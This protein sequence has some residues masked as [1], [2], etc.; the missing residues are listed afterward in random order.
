MKV[1]GA[2]FTSH[3]ILQ[4]MSDISTSKA[5]QSVLNQIKDC[6]IKLRNSRPESREGTYMV[7]PSEESTISEGS[8]ELMDYGIRVAI[9]IDSSESDV[10]LD[11]SSNELPNMYEEILEII[12][13]NIRAG[14]E[15]N[16]WEDYYGDIN[17]ESRGVRESIFKK[18]GDIVIEIIV[19]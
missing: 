3:L 1:I 2:F 10:V 5:D 4:L 16:N 15:E 12:I 7:T 6:I 18:D 19:S 13:N 11:T 14:I 8:I 9:H 17:R